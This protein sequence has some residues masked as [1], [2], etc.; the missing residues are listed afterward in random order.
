MRACNAV[1]DV[2]E[3][4]PIW[5]ILPIRVGVTAVV[6]LMLVVSAA[7]VIFTGNIAKVVGDK[8]GLRPAAVL[9]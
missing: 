4:R 3:G 7:I 2:P 1:Y 5:K 9:T 6:G 8:I